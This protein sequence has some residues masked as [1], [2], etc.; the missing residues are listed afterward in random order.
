[1]KKIHLSRRGFLRGVGAV[2]ALPVLESL[3]GTRVLADVATTGA[4]MATTPAG[5]PLR[6]GFVAFAN[7][8]NYDHWAPTGVGRS[9][10][11]N[12]AFKAVV[13]L[14][15]RF[16][17]ITNLSSDP[18]KDWGDGESRQGALG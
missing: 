6:M 12:E 8:V 17:V 14:K 10:V 1:M 9:F 2:V 18:G 16:Q 15:D 3:P 7:G 13:D 5:M 11:L 4:P